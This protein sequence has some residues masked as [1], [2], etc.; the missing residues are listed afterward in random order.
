MKKLLPIIAGLCCGLAQAQSASPPPPVE[1]TAEQDQRRLLDLL[2]IASLRPGAN[3]RDASSPNAP[4]YDEA[5]AKYTA[6]PD[7]LVLK[8]G[9]RVKSAKAW[10]GERRPQ[11]VEDFD[12]EVYGRM[13]S[14]VP[15]VK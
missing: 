5:K 4:N 7:P 10:W 15:G 8:K 9:E 6:L 11:I 13:P 1:L 12:R 2:H 3:P 14:Y